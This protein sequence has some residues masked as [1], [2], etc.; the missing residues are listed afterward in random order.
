MKEMTVK[1]RFAPSL[2]SKVAL[3]FTGATAT[4]MTHPVYA[5]AEQWATDAATYATGPG[6]DSAMVVIAGLAALV[7][8]LIVARKLGFR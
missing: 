2:R 4:V 5:Q 3:A 6:K 7:I 8:L 1:K